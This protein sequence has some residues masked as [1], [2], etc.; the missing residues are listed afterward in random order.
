MPPIRNRLKFAQE[1]TATRVVGC[2]VRRI[3]MFDIGFWLSMVDQIIREIAFIGTR[4]KQVL[5]ISE[6]LSLSGF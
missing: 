3:N 1:N 2:K 6:H 5:P 4:I